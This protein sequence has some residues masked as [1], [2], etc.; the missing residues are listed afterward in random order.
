MKL[1]LITSLILVWTLS[2]LIGH[3][4]WKPDEAY[5]FGLPHVT[6][7]QFTFWHSGV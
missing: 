7:R 3:D 1:S 4:P 2:G 5:S 6:A